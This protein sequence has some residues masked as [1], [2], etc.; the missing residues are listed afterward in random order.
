MNSKYILLY[1]IIFSLSAL[2]CGCSTDSDKAVKAAAIIIFI[3]LFLG[4]SLFTA[5]MTYRIKRKN[6]ISES[7]QTHEKE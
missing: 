5:M 1:T 6:K 3:A 2:L 4:T 7:D